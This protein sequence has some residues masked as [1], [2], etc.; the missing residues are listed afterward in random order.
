MGCQLA[1]PG[2]LTHVCWY[3]SCDG[4][5]AMLEQGHIKEMLGEFRIIEKGAVYKAYVENMAAKVVCEK[6]PDL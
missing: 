1:N 6:G 4:G 3:L 5:S 2:D